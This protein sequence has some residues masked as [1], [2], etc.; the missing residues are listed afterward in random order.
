MVRS[1][2]AGLWP[3]LVAVSTRRARREESCT[4]SIPVGASKP[5]CR[6]DSREIL[7][8]NDSRSLVLLRADQ[9]AAQTRRRSSA[10]A[11]AACGSP[12]RCPAARRRSRRPER[13][14]PRR[15]ERPAHN[16]PSR[17]RRSVPTPLACASESAARTRGASA[18]ATLAPP[19]TQVNQR[20]PGSPA[21][22]RS[23]GPA[24]VEHPNPG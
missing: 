3:I 2:T 1:S 20:R 18:Q 12:T 8:R 17:R 24:T 11:P 5:L 6:A 14:D 10:I 9:R 13:R 15:A 4:G 23:P 16:R 7:G 21:P 19:G 22:R